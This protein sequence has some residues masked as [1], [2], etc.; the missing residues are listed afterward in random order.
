[1]DL[2]QFKLIEEYTHC[3]LKC[4]KEFEVVVHK[5]YDFNMYSIQD[6]EEAIYV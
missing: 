1:M 2:V 3:N 4:C 5:M 6:Q